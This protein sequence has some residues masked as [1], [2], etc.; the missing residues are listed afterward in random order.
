MVLIDA[1]K[2]FNPQTSQF[3][4]N[5]PSAGS[6]TNVHNYLWRFSEHCSQPIMPPPRKRGGSHTSQ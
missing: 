4:S 1:S 5:L 3:L 2:V 6:F